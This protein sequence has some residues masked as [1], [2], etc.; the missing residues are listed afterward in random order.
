MYMLNNNIICVTNRRLCERP[1]KEQI[2]RIS[3]KGIKNIILREKDLN[4]Q[5]Y[6]RLAEEITEYCPD[7]NLIIHSFVTTAKAL[8]I[9]AIHMP[10]SLMNNKIS[11]EFK[12]IGC[13]VHSVEQALQAVEM[14]ATYLTAGH[15][16]A[17]SCKPDLPPRGIEFLK[18]VCNAVDIPVYAIG[19][20]NEN[21]LKTVMEAGAK[22]GCIMSGLMKI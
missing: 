21:N 16:F 11:S 8:K 4:E 10:L 7:V 19:G 1:L 18:D 6:F 2:K 13:S 5:E 14:G 20:I 22:G 17:T 15:I 9:N 12:T 3:E